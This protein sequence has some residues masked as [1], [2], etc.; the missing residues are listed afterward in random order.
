MK[1]NKFIYI[2]SFLLIVTLFVSLSVTYFVV[3]KSNQGVSNVSSQYFDIVFSDPIINFDSDM[4]VI[5][6]KDNDKVKIDIPNLNEFNKSNSFS[7]DVKNIGNID[8]YVDKYFINNLNSNIDTSEFNVDIS[9]IE[10]EIIKGSES[11]KII[12]TIT[13]YGKDVSTSEK[14]YI[15]FDL[16][17]LFKEVIL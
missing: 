14:P 9:L 5:V 12:I 10:N 1:D 8:A 2:M 3:E 6:D 15:S 13:Y 11:E 7:I 16:N 4:K 17:Y